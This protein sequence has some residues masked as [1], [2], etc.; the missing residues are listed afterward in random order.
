MI[1]HLIRAVNDLRDPACWGVVGKSVALTLGLLALG[2][3]GLGLLLGFDALTFTLPWIGPVDLSG[4]GVAAYVVG[5]IFG[6]ALLTPL[7]AS[8]FIGLLLDDV[9]DAV[10]TR[11]YPDAGPATPVPFLTQMGAGLKLLGVMIVANLLGLVIYLVFA[12]LAPFTF[13]AIN[14]YLIGREYFELVAMRRMEATA[15][16]TL[17]R[18]LRLSATLIGAVVAALLAIPVLNLFAPLLGVAALTHLYHRRAA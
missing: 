12:P 3:G 13:L 18:K 11:R 14:G 1:G 5:A 10:E 2:F 9:V 8:L 15:A 4:L 16:R 6:S 17:R 7:V